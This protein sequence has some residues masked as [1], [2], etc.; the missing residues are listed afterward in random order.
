MPKLEEMDCKQIKSQVLAYAEDTLPAEARSAVDEHLAVCHSCR[1]LVAHFCTFEAIINNDRTLE[2]NPFSSTRILQHIEN[3]LESG[4]PGVL[5]RLATV[6]RPVLVA[7]SLAIA[8]LIGWAIG[9]SQANRSAL[10]SG[11]QTIETLRTELFITELM[12]E[13]KTFFTNQ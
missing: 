12:D 11:D 10:A 2:P 9:N 3:E 7:V 13:D 5:H 8:L 1:E 6:L 4:Q